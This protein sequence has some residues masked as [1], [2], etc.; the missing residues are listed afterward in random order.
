M[1]AQFVSGCA[2]HYS[3]VDIC[4]ANLSEFEVSLSI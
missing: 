3:W 1:E 2:G 4:T